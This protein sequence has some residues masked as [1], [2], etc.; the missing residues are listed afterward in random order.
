MC[1]DLSDNLLFFRNAS[2]HGRVKVRADSGMPSHLQRIGLCHKSCVRGTADCD[3]HTKMVVRIRK[4]DIDTLQDHEFVDTEMYCRC[5]IGEA[6]GIRLREVIHV[7]LKDAS[8]DFTVM[9]IHI[10]HSLGTRRG[11]RSC[12]L[13]GNI[14]NFTLSPD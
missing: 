11:R 6:L 2:H 14:T 9:A 7:K 13:T 3:A 12:I 1:V 5:A 10:L 4:G 8:M